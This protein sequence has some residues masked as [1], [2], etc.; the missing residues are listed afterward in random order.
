MLDTIPVRTGEELPIQELDDFLRRTL[1]DLPDGKLKVQQ[2]SA[3]HSNLT[4]ALKI[5]DWEAVLR[6]PPLGPIAPKA[7]DMAR[8]SKLLSV[9]HEL[10]SLAPKP[11]LFHDGS[12]VIGSPFFIMERRHGVVLDTSFPEGTAP[13]EKVCH[14]ISESFVDTLVQLHEA[15]YKGTALEQI[16]HPDG[17]MERQVN[18]WIRRYERAKTNEIREVEELTEWLS[19]NVPQSQEPTIIH[20]DFKCNNMMFAKNDLTKVVGVFDWEMSTIGDPLADVGAAMSYWVQRDD[21]EFL[22]YGLGK[23]PITVQKGF[24]TRNALIEM[25]AKKSGRDLSHI[26]FYVTFAYFKLAVIVQQIFYRY[27]KGQTQD[28][29][30]ANMDKFVYGLV[31]HAFEQSRTKE[32]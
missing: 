12:E 20:Y 10:F 29:R 23:P 27:K 21:P 22:Q 17:F 15:N 6:R 11:Y 1:N 5:G 32:V 31:Q 24:M 28:P 13:T 8:E 19:S 26:H 3:G 18:G 25:Y 4:Y 9:L 30:F 2:F 16:G 7:H 14:S